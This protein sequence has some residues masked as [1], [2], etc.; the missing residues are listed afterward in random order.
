MVDPTFI[1]SGPTKV[2]KDHVILIDGIIERGGGRV[3]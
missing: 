1:G 3:V 2:V